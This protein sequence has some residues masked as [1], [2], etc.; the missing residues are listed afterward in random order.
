LHANERGTKTAL[1]NHN[2]CFFGH[3]FKRW[4]NAFRIYEF[5]KI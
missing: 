3:L 5:D 4:K 1:F 2:I